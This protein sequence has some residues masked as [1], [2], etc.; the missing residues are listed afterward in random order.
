M[1]LV[2]PPTGTLLDVHAIRSALEALGESVLVAGDGRAVKVHVHSER[3]DQIIEYG[4]GL[5]ALSRISVENLD[6]QARD[7]RELRAEAFT[8]TGD[9]AVTHAAGKAR[10][11]D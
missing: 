2:Q 11:T 7:V 9:A 5:G 3:P 4:L 1:F 10:D 6:A 8:G